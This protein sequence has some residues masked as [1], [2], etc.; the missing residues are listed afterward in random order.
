MLRRPLA[1]VVAATAVSVVAVLTA[2]VSAPAAAARNGKCIANGPKFV[3]HPAHYGPTIRG[4]TY[5]VTTMSLSGTGSLSCPR[6][7]AVLARIFR[8]NR[9]LP[10]RNAPLKGG[11]PGFQCQGLSLPPPDVAVQGLCAKSNAGGGPGQLFQW[12]PVDPKLVH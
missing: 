4:T 1:A 6:I 8:A 11:P 3:I 2:G 10:H 7:K 5:L 9:T 12:A